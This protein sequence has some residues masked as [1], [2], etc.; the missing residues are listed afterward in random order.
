MNPQ[1]SSSKSSESDQN[2]ESSNNQ[3]KSSIKPLQLIVRNLNY[4]TGEEQLRQLFASIGSVISVFIPVTS[5]RG[6]GYGFVTMED[7]ESAN[8]CILKLDGIEVDGRKLKLKT[9]ALL[10]LI[11]CEMN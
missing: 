5:G 10:F 11:L 1:Q 9:M 4:K 7:E 6:R 2:Q 8:K 3:N